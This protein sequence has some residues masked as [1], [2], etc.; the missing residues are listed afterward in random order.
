MLFFRIGPKIGRSFEFF[1]ETEQRFLKKLT[2][3][4]KKFNNI[5]WFIKKFH[6]FALQNKKSQ[7][8]L[9]HF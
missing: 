4:L 6:I 1:T 3:I 2:K 7:N 5:F 8:T 9:W